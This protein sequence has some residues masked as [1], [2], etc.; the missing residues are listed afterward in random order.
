MQNSLESLLLPQNI[1]YQYP[2]CLTA[3][4]RV[5]EQGNSTKSPTL[6]ESGK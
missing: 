3:D 2:V 4:C 6:A 5:E 1:Y